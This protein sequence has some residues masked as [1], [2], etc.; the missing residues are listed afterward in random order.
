MINLSF[1]EAA[2]SEREDS[3]V[4]GISG[5]VLVVRPW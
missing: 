2:W 1:E 5:L 4:G 3:Q